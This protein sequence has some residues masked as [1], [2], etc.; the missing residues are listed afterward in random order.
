MPKKIKNIEDAAETKKPKA[1]TK[2]SQTKKKPTAKKTKNQD[3]APKPQKPTEVATPTLTVHPYQRQAIE[4]IKA[5]SGCGLFLDVGLG[6]TATVLQFLYEENPPCN[7]LIIAPKNIAVSTWPQ[8]IEKWNFPF[9]YVS[10]VT[11]KKGIKLNM[12]ARDALL[13]KIPNCNPP[14]IFLANREIVTKIVDYYTERGIPWPFPVVIIDELQSFKNPSSERFK[15]L[16]KVRPQI[17]RLIGMTGTPIPNGLLDLWSEIWLMDEGY[18]LEKTMTKYQDRYFYRFAMQNGDG[19]TFY[20][21]SPAPGAKEYIWKNVEDIVI[22]MSNQN[23]QLPPVTYNNVSVQMTPEE[24]AKYKEFAETYV[25]EFAEEDEDG[26]LFIEAKN[27]GVLNARLRQLASGAVY[28]NRD[29]DNPDLS[30]DAYE[31]LHDHKLTALHAIA[32]DTDGPL[33]VCYHFHSDRDSILDY[34]DGKVHKDG[35]RPKAVAFDGKRAPQM[36]DAWNRGE[37]EIMLIQPAAAGH[38]LNLQ[39]GGHTLVWYTLSWSLEEYL[40]ANG[41]LNRQGQTKPVVIH[42]L[43]C[44][45]TI[46]TKVI[47][48][49]SHKEKDQQLFLD[50]VALPDLTTQ[51]GRLDSED[52]LQDTINDI[53]PDACIKV[54]K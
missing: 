31:L 37:Y 22:S 30:T 1:K 10:L 13:A 54:Q 44:N 36:I 27:A 51:G 43:L 3:A 26:G 4:F 21:Y 34:F 45:K 11:N 49:L 12:K 2:K 41:R 9:N 19:N 39:Y 25:L 14:R 33:L 35:R 15:A 32:N 16:K 29:G 6:K 20:K 46:D 23:I 47:A 5:R 52:I 53:L 48:R 17:V 42:H 8:E 7:V 24:E 18:R 38:G 40:Q 28:T 50:A